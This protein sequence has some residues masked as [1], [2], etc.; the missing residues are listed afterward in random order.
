MYQ[1]IS[2]SKK[3]FDSCG[4]IVLDVDCFKLVNDNYGHLFGDKVLARLAMLLKEVFRDN[5]SILMRADGDEFVIFVKDILNIGVS[6]R[7]WSF[8]RSEIF[9][10]GRQVVRSHV[11]MLLLSSRECS[12][13][14]YD[15]LFENADIALYK[16]KERGKNCYVYCDSLQH[17]S[18]MIAEQE[19]QEEMLEARYFQNDIVA[20]AFEIFEKTNNFEV[21]IHL[22]LKVIG[23]RLELDR[24][25]IVQTD[26]KAREIY[27]DYQ[28]NREGIPKG[29]ETVRH[30]DK[31][32]FSQY[33]MILM[34]M[35]CLFY[36]MIICNDIPNQ[37]RRS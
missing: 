6:W 12:S 2:E 10:S 1:Q 34:R 16:A 26:I 29:L 36:S 15:Q 22:L 5:D 19:K 21:A 28:W 20:T 17:F 27:S 33:L 7:M 23:V 25:T 37:Q 24:I 8:R 13:V 3:P 14:T 4:M 32:D 18:S 30:F 9:N 35:G 11:G 31:E